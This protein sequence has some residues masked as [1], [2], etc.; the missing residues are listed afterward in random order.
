HV[1]RHLQSARVRI[2]TEERREG[3]RDLLALAWLEC[4]GDGRRRGLAG[5][6]D[7]SDR[8]GRGARARIREIQRRGETC[9]GEADDL[10]RTREDLK[11]RRCVGPR[12]A[13]VREKNG[14]GKKADRKPRDSP[15][16]VRLQLSDRKSTRLN[17]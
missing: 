2:Q 16:H 12:S 7:E 14:T 11:V 8:D 1:A 4:A 5:E 17:S 10:G 13:K 3:C 6:R 9:T 15:N